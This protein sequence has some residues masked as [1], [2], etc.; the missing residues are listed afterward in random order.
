[1]NA[2]NVIHLYSYIKALVDPLVQKPP[3]LIPRNASHVQPITAENAQ[4][5]EKYANDV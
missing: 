3:G 4:V 1:M 2:P 5:T